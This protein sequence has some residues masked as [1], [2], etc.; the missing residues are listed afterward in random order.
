MS[1]FVNKSWGY[2][3]CLVNNELYCSKILHI[4]KDHC[5][6][7]HYHKIKDETF[8]IL[9]GHIILDFNDKTFF[10]Y[11]GNSIR[12]K[13]KDKHRFFGIEDTDIIEISTQHFDEDSYR[14]IESDR[15]FEKY[16]EGL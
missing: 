7:Y 13:P 9:K 8:Y 12:I 5:C 3:Y 2:E 16:K 1:K 14:L 4:D 10:M 11:A 6:S 15:C